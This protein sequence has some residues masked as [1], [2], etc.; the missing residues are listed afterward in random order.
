[1]AAEAVLR[2]LIFEVPGAVAVL[3]VDTSVHA[4]ER[5]ARLLGVIE[6]GGLPT[7]GGVTVAAAGTA[8]TTMY[9]IRRMAGH[10]L[11]RGAFV[12]IAE[13]AAHAGDLCML[14]LERKC[15]PVVVELY[16]PPD[17][18]FVAGGAIAAEFALVRLV[19]LVTID[20]TGGGFPICLAGLMTIAAVECRMCAVQWKLSALVV[21]LVAAQLHDVTTA[22]QMLRM[23]CTALGR[24]DTGQF[25]VETVPGADV[26]G[27]LLVAIQTQACLT[28]AIAAIMTLRALLLIFL[29]SCAELARHEESLRIHGCAA[30][31]RQETK[32]E[33][34]QEQRMTCSLPHVSSRFGRQ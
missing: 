33:R 26:S 17:G 14:V 8:L 16:S 5:E 34:E 7:G 12:S 31:G 15:R 24:S 13:V 25:A 29:M 32:Q 30:P 23:T 3:T 11:L 9:V 22:T 18:V 1:M 28:V 10:T 20:T 4:L 27:D 19:L 6:L 21:E 2:H